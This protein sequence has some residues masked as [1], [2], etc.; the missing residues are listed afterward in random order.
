MVQVWDSQNLFRV[1][2]WRGSLYGKPKS[3]MGKLLDSETHSDVEVILKSVTFV[4]A[5]KVFLS[6]STDFKGQLEGAKSVPFEAVL[7]GW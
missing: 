2:A 3:E 4:L 5:H 1:R 7:M 6:R